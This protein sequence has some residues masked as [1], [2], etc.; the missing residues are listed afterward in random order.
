M[1]YIKHN[2]LLNTS[3]LLHFFQQLYIL[4]LVLIILEKFLQVTDVCFTYF[5]VFHKKSVKI[6]K[7][8]SGCRT[9]ENLG[10][11]TCAS[12]GKGTRVG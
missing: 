4:F 9:S 11:M 1:S 5:F 7:F 10:K 8:I 3:A 2:G 12:L 6:V